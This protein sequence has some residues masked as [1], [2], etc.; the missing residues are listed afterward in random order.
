ME[1]KFLLYKHG[2]QANLQTLKNVVQTPRDE[3]FDHEDL[4]W[5]IVI[6]HIG[7]QQGLVEIAFIPTTQ[8]FDF[9]V[10]EKVKMVDDV[11]FFAKNISSTLTMICINRK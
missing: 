2:H 7:M 6:R 3:L 5:E 1:G 10:G 4:L 9:I 8:M 11:I